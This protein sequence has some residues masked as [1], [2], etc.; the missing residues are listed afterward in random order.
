MTPVALRTLL[1]RPLFSR[2]APLDVENAASRISAYIYGNVLILA[3]LIPLTRED[4]EHWVG[5]AI[6]VGT[7]LSTFLAHALAE[8]VGRSARAGRPLT[9]LER[10]AELRDSVPILSSAAL[11]TAF[12]TI[13]WLGWLDPVVGQVIAEITVILRIGST[14]V[15]IERLRGERPGR[16]TYLGAIGLAVVATVAA[17]IKLRLTH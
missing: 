4:D 17:L 12:L 13:G 14:A 7:A 8:A 6:V 1:N 9:L 10:R 16:A 2:N 5:V 3:A 11:P 15:I